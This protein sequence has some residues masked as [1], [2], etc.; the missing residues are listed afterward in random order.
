MPKKLAYH[1]SLLVDDSVYIH[2]GIEYPNITNED[3]FVFNMHT[4][5]WKNITTKHDCGQAPAHHKTVCYIWK[6][7]NLVV[8][9]FDTR[10]KKTC[11]AILDLESE[12]WTT[13]KDD[14]RN[15][16]VGGYIFK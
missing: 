8:A 9:T 12:T 14:G 11:T 13:L 7:S 1:C 16:V 2:G 5:K 4:K 10:S 6:G 3:T 15:Y